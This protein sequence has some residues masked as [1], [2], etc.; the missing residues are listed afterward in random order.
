MSGLTGFMITNQLRRL[1]CTLLPSAFA[2][3]A[4][5][6]GTLD[7]CAAIHIT[8][9]TP[10]SGPVGTAV[11][12]SGDGFSTVASNNAVFINGMRAPVT[13]AAANSLT[14]TIPPGTTYGTFSVSA[15]G[16]TAESKLG[17]AVTFP[18]R[19]L[20]ADA[21]GVPSTFSPGTYPTP[22]DVADL[23]GDGRPDLVEVNHFNIGIYRNDGT[24]SVAG[25]FTLV[26]SLPTSEIPGDVRLS[27]IDGDGKLD[28]VAVNYTDSS[29][30]V[31]RNTTTN[32]AINFAPKVSFPLTD[33]RSYIA[34]AD[35]DGDGRLDIIVP[36]FSGGNIRV[37]RNTS[38][39]GS[40]SFA[41]PVDFPTMA[42]PSDVTVQDLDGDGK[43]DVV[44]LHHIAS[45]TALEVMHNVSTPGVI[46]SNSLP[47]TATLNAN[48]NYVVIADLDSDGRPD[49]VAGAIYT[50]NLT[51][52]QNL[53]TTGNLSNSA[54]GPPVILP[55]AGVT[56][57]IAVSDLDGDGR[58]DLIAAT[59]LS[60]SVG[61][62]R[63]VGGTNGIDASWFAPRFDLA[64]GW[65]ADGISISD[66]D[67]DGLPD[68]LFCSLYANEIWVYR[69][70]VLTT[71][72]IVTEPTNVTVGLGGNVSLTVQATGG[73][74][75][76]A[77][78]H[79]GALVS[80]ATAATLQI[81][82]AHGINAGDY[83]V[84]VSNSGGAVTS[85][86]A[87]VTVTVDRTLALGAVADVNE[88]DQISTPLTLTSSGDV[89]GID[90][91]IN[92]D[93]TYLAMPEIVWDS[94]LDSAL[95]EFSV[96]RRGQLRGIIA[97]PATAIPAGTQT[98]ATI[99]FR[100]RTIIQ[101]NVHVSLG[102]NISDMSDAM[103]N[104]I[105]G[106]T[107]VV[108]TDFSIHDVGFLA[109]D[110]NGN[111]QLD[112]GD[113]SLL[114]RLLA[115]LDTTRYWDISA[116]DFNLNQHLDSGD[117][118]KMLR[119][120]A[121]MDPPPQPPQEPPSSNKVYGAKSL[122]SASPIIAPELASLSPALLQGSNGQLVTVQVRLDVVRTLISGASF[123]LDYP[124]QALRLRNAQSHRIGSS[125]PSGTLA[126]WNI[127][128]DQTNYVTQNG[129]I[130]LAL[131][132]STA[133][134]ASNAV[135]A[136]FT[137]E[138]QPGASS[139]YLWPLTIGALQITGD[140]FNTRTLGP[141]VAA[142]VGRPALSGRMTRLSVVRGGDVSFRFDGDA[143]ANYRI[144][145]S[146]DLA[147]WKLLREVLNH[148]GP[149]DIS[150]PDAGSRVQRFYR[151]VPF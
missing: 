63:N 83:Y 75:H 10:A 127:A 44:V 35:L 55:V 61:I 136:E 53:S 143:G 21:F 56:K 103:G 137:F 126:V 27:D 79:N 129:H 71:P 84:I 42:N 48:G 34:V 67:M 89:G 33:A 74:L 69:G 3:I 133:W 116:N 146:D 148:S 46:N 139:R 138:V 14:V 90:F 85:E 140:G 59:E 105:V 50:H 41:S 37:L 104:P 51:V 8:D 102:L 62:Y 22:T 20:N 95:K 72:A 40:I 77:W 144:E 110:N 149:I 36:S 65:N 117:V 54:F 82:N 113:A 151:N 96:P 112:I 123:T 45:I 39:P 141:L 9:F 73:G 93:A 94:S 81:Y 100:A 28:I 64:A 66:F 132:G 131:S 29:V 80:G 13:A 122:R 147:Q 43:P 150:D 97:L 17:F 121:G 98:L 78:Y 114:M 106:G 4:L 101:T 31:F 76:Y 18:L 5:V 120:I 58:L 7:A 99:Q 87:T 92:Y 1:Q 111:Q 142:F 60:D 88:G 2:L 86:V 70:I 49:I 47:I 30:S 38:G 24:G 11:T 130:T 91:V 57:R 107:D 128:P 119:V 124:V 12:L 15:N 32:G 23:D 134:S 108:G 25:L 68:I 6:L 52:I 125:V 109:G 16:L 26:L 19:T 118:I 145:Y 115:Q 135:L